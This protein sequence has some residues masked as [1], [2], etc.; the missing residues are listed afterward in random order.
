MLIYQVEMAKNPLRALDRERKGRSSEP[1]RPAAMARRPGA[2]V[3][4]RN[5]GLVGPPPPVAR[6]PCDG[7]ARVA[8]GGRSTAGSVCKMLGCSRV[9]L[10]ISEDE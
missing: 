3:T 2:L 10:A 4:N 9:S 8:M 7:R 1:A 6:G 5:K